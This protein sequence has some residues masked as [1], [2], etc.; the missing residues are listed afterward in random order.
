MSCL[1]NWDQT[2][3]QVQSTLFDSGRLRKDSKLLEKKIDTQSLLGI[4]Y[5]NFGWGI[6][7][8]IWKEVKHIENDREKWDERFNTQG[9]CWSCKTGLWSSFQVI[10][11]RGERWN[12]EVNKDVADAVEDVE[13]KVKSV[14]GMEG[15]EGNKEDYESRPKKLQF[16]F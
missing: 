6:R 3:G 14:I 12:F 11:K 13:D 9:A 16:D 2:N 8:R 5:H 15:D 7:K 10:I 4:K 1:Q